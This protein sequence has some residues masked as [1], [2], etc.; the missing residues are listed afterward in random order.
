MALVAWLG[1][2]LMVFL[3]DPE[4]VRDVGTKGL[5]L[6]F[7]VVAGG[8]VFLSLN[9]WIKPG[10]RTLVYSIAVMMVVYLRLFRLLGGLEIVLIVGMVAV[11]EVVFGK[12]SSKS[13]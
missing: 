4:L 2:G 13:E 8:V 3:V 12:I 7:G 6:P 9:V 1:L 5:Y 11:W 10:V